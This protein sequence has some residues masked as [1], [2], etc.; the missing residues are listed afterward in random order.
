[1]KMGN[2][3]LGIDPGLRHTGWG[4][5]TSEGS[6]LRFV[7]CG[8]IHPPASGEL[9]ARLHHLHEQL[10][11]VIRLYQPESC[12]IEQTFVST[13]AASTLKLGNARGALLLS[14]AIQGLRVAE[15][16]ATMVKKTVTGSGRA[17]KGQIERMVRMLLPACTEAASSDAMDAL[18]VAITHAHHHSFAK[19]LSS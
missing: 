2:T 18:A 5:I 9:A 4:V 12:A 13:N 3:I 8:A 11:Q 14:L 1:M 17:D 10:E 19:A 6:S 7:A 15:Y 16:D